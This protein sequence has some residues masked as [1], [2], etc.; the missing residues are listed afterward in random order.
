MS[1]L[2]IVT[3]DLHGAESKHYSQVKRK[4]NTLNLEKQIHTKD[5]NYPTDL[6]ANTF[7]AKFESNWNEQTAT[8]LRDYLR[9]EV[10]EAISTLNLKATI[11]VVVGSKWAWGRR[12]V[13]IRKKKI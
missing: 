7:A 4:L 11:F 6:P 9:S 13:G 2:A 10:A 12:R 8:E 3:F 1:L 5:N